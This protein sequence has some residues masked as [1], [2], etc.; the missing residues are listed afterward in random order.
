LK[1]IIKAHLSTRRR[2]DLLEQLAAWQHEMSTVVP[3]RA[4]G[5]I[6]QVRRAEELPRLRPLKV[7]PADLALRYPVMVG[8][9]G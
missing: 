7:A 6:P 5:I 1:Y 4:T 8:P 2:D 3:S 9:T